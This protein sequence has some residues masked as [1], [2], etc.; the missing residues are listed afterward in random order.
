MPPYKP[1]E[2]KT[3]L[4]AILSALLVLGLAIGLVIYSLITGAERPILEEELIEDEN[5]NLNLN[6]NFENSIPDSAPNVA[7]PTFAPPGN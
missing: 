6:P 4:P 1:G 3:Y 5:G 2:E 7:P